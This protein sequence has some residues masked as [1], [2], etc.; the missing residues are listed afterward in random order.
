MLAVCSKGLE[1]AIGIRDLEDELVVLGLCEANFCSEAREHELG[2]G[3]V[4][5]MKKVVQ[6]GSCVWS[7]IRKIPLPPS[8]EFHDYSDIAL[9]E[10]GRVAITSQEDSKVWI[11]TLTGRNEKG[12]WNIDALAF[13]DEDAQVYDFPKNENCKTIY[14]NIEGIE[15]MGEHMLL[16]VSDRMKK[17]GKQHFR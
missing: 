6:D 14:C 12:L 13:N 2:N 16:A 15:W 4:I 5:A 1:G 11:G 10:S 8:L 17:N 3:R 9:D 7:T